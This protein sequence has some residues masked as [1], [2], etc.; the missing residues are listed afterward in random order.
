MECQNDLQRWLNH[1]SCPAFSV[2]ENRIVAC[3]QAAEGLL[4]LPGAD[5]RQLLLTG[6][7][8]LET[9]QE[10]CLYLKLNLSSEGYGAAV[11][12]QGDGLLFLLEQDPE[13][14]AL[15]SLA[16]AARELRNPLSNLIIA[17]DKLTQ[18]SQEDPSARE[19]MARLNRSLNQMHRLI[20]NMSDAARQDVLSKAGLHEWNKLI[21]DIFERVQTQLAHTKVQLTYEGLL[22]TVYGYC[23]EGQLERAI[24]NVVSNAMKFMPEDGR[25]HAKLTRHGNMLHLSMTDTGSGIAGNVL[26][27]IFCRY[28]RQPSIEDSRFGLGLGMVLIRNAAANHGGT[29]LID[30]PD[31]KGTRVT[32]TLA[33][34]QDSS[35]FKEPIQTFHADD[36]M[37]ILRELADC[38]PWEAYQKD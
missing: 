19:W 9:F 17:S 18:F 4:I 27:N 30:S 25:I 5:V 26:D 15:R 23:K 2:N 3:N 29:V 33:I 21:Y 34:R 8:V 13:D 24:L 20:N 31:G 12:R 37:G 14:A 7:E 22:E 28:Q 35:A 11:T 10:G 38:L 32:M 1:F 6:Q 16:L 36:S